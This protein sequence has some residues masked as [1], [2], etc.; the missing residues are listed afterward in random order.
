MLYGINVNISDGPQFFLLSP[1]FLN[2]NLN[3]T[4][5]LDLAS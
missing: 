2:S 4:L 3:Q 1:P 5:Q